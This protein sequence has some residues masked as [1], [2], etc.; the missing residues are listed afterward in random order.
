MAYA[1]SEGRS[2]VSLLIGWWTYRSL[3][4]DP[5]ISKDFNDLEFGRG[6]LVIE[7]SSARGTLAS[8]MSEKNRWKDLH[9]P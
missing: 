8:R 4:N 3:I 2:V 5:D 6:D 7:D 9:S 1:E